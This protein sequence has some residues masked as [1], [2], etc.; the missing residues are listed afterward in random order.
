[1]LRV[2]LDDEGVIDRGHWWV[3]TLGLLV[4]LASL[5]G[6]VNSVPALAAY[7]SGLMLFLALAALV[8][9]HTMNIKRLR[10][11][12]RPEWLALAAAIPPAFAALS[13][14]FRPAT[15]PLGTLDMVIGSAML[16][17][18]LWAVL[19]LGFGPSKPQPNRSFLH[20]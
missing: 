6:L 2:Y 18:A 11:R 4:V 7:A 9:F 17:V 14:A 20:A 15:G 12:R 13:T 16:L 3:G 5:E 1:M 19:D 8:P 10:D